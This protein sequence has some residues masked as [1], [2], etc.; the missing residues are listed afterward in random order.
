MT[1]RL[2]EK[3]HTQNG[4]NWEYVRAFLAVARTGR[5]TAAAARM[6]TD[7][8]T[9]SRRIN[10]LE[11]DLD[12]TLFVRSP[13]GYALTEQGERFQETAEGMEKLAQQAMDRVGGLDSALTG[14]VRIGA[15]EGFGSYFLAPRLG[16]LIDDHPGFNVELVSGPGLYSLSKREADI[17]VTIS[18]PTE[19]RLV[20]RKLIDFELGLFASR[21]YL[22]N[23]VEISSAADLVHHRFVGYISDLLYTPELDYIQDVHPGID[24]TIESNN[25]VTQVAA[26]LAGAGLCILPSFI[27]HSRS[28]LAPVLADEIRLNRSFWLV[29]H[30]DMRELERIK[31]TAKF[32]V[33]QVKQ[34]TKLFTL[35]KTQ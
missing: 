7:H 25:L 24:T 19:G 15:P 26:V 18:R 10:D 17:V 20:V 22:A 32:L 23:N 8:A 6:Q 12:T 27:A 34:N 29:T 16:G 9:V 35:P 2:C 11:R 33:E 28:E 4:F 14:T 5:L 21:E 1:K 13:R 30:N 31:V 3:P